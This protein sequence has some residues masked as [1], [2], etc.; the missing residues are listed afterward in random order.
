VK[1]VVFFDVTPRD[2]CKKQ[3]FE[4]GYRLQHQGDKIQLAK[5]DVS[6]N[7][8]PK[9]AEKKYLVLLAR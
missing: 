9:H 4:G 5:K 2:S 6:N 8:Q 7:S 1:N 3:S